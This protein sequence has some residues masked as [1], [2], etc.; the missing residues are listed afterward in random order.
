MRLSPLSRTRAR[1]LLVVSIC[2]IT[3]VL[4]S[5]EGRRQHAASILANSTSD[6]ANGSDGLC[7]LRE[8]ITAANNN[9][10][11]GAGAG[12]CI[13]RSSSGADVID[14]TGVTDTIK[15]TGALR[16]ITS[17]M[18]ITGPGSSQLTAR[19]DTGGDY[20][21][22]S[23]SNATV[24]ISGLTATNGRTPDADCIFLGAPVHKT[25][26]ASRIQVP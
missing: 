10:A 12:E 1:A 7:T 4:I 16:N 15:L 3:I 8:A 11:S 9:A 25:V 2:V 5:F 19:R 24:T 17:S 13:A 21:M 26:G 22:F 6:A 20:R 18:T 14:A 23:V